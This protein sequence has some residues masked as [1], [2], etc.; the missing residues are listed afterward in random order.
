MKQ[1]LCLN[2]GSNEWNISSKSPNVKWINIDADKNDKINPDLQCRAEELPFEDN[3]IDEIYSGHLLE[4]FDIHEGKKALNEWYRVLKL[5]GI[6]TITVPDIE[7]GLKCL[8]DGE[9]NLEWFNQ[10]V[11]GANDRQKQEHHQAFNIDILAHQ[12]SELFKELTQVDDCPY[13]VANVKWQSCIQG[14]K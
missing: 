2:L 3:S 10:I 5:G 1:K 11:Y 6:I 8:L 13:W 14:K 12:M 7:K 4:H 9:I